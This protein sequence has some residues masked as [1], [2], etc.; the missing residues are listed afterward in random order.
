M[1]SGMVSISQAEI[2]A[3]HSFQTQVLK[4]IDSH[5]AVPNPSAQQTEPLFLALLFS[6]GAIHVGND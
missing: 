4:K 1:K 2:R 3:L 6:N 5:P